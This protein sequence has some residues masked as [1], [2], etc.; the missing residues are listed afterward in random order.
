[1]RGGVCGL[2]GMVGDTLFFFFFGSPFGFVYVPPC[3]SEKQLCVYLLLG[4]CG[5]LING[6]ERASCCARQLT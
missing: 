2:D 5:L 6:L 4:Y 1:M 3:E